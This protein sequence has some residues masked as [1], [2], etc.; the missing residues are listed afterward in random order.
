MRRE[1]NSSPISAAVFAFFAKHKQPDV[2]V[3]NRWHKCSSLRLSCFLSWV[4]IPS[5]RSVSS[6]LQAELSFCAAFLS[7]S[8]CS[9]AS[10]LSF[11]APSLLS[12]ASCIA[13]PTGLFTTSKFASSK[14]I[15]M[16]CTSYFL[17]LKWLLRSQVR[18]RH[19]Q[20][21]FAYPQAK[22]GHLTTHLAF[23]RQ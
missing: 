7:V 20:W 21:Q 19:Q 2:P 1:E 4:T 14:R 15:G 5:V 10:A 13:T 18:Q 3:S 11:G 9:I 17:T 8:S 12:R 22:Q 16:G 6:P 23:L